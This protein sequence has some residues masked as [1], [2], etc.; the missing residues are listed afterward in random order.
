MKRISLVFW[1]SQVVGFQVFSQSST[2]YTLRQSVEEGIKNNIQLQINQLNIESAEVNYVQAK[3]N[4]LPNL[5]ASASQSENFGRNVDP[6]TYEFKNQQISSNNIG[7]SSNLTLFNGFRIQNSIKQNEYSR[8]A[9]R[10]EYKDTRN[11]LI[12]NI[13]NAYIQVLFNKE[14][15]NN[16]KNQVLVTTTQVERTQKLVRAGTLPEGNVLNLRSQQATDELNV[17][18]ASNQLTIAKLNLLQFMNVPLESSSPDMIDIENPAIVLDTNATQDDVREIYKTAE[19]TQPSIKGA[20]LRI[21]S[22]EI[23]IKVAQGNKYP[24]LVLS[25]NLFT[26][27]ANTRTKIG[28]EYLGYQ[29][30]GFILNN[31]PTQ[32]IYGP[33]FRTTQANYSLPSQWVD[34]FSQ[35]LSLNLNIPIFNNFQVKNGVQSAIITNK[36]AELNYENTKVQLRRRIEQ[37]F[38]DMKAA[39]KK[40][41]AVQTQVFANEE[42]FRIN[43][44]RFNAGVI[45]SVDYTI[46]SNNLNRSR[47]ELLQAKYDLFLKMKVLDFYKGNELIY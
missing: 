25:G 3:A 14:L 4:R 15:L 13:V 20:I 11:N 37:A 36:N 27:Y 29:P 42:A 8:E 33:S 46:S 6:T 21:K 9:S 23:G 38:V 24:R 30:N 44:K 16:N 43:E 19:K 41:E 10:Y 17:I 45:N 40:F 32:L 35:S 7:L 22:A 34:N 39:Q 12:L 5:N 47:S 18:N 28:V 2:I 1:I 31:D 26:Q